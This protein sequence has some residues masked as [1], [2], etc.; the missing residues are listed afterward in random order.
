MIEQ[1][2]TN[3]QRRKLRP[4]VITLGSK[5]KAYIEALFNEPCM[6]DHFEP[7]AFSPGIPSRELRSCY[8]FFSHASKTGI[9]P[10]HEWDAIAKAK[11][12]IMN[13]DKVDD[14]NHLGLL[15]CLNDIP[16]LEGRR[17]SD[18]DV[19]KHY[20][21]ELWKKAK[22]INRGRNVLGCLFAHLIAMKKMVE[23]DYDFILEDNVRAP[24][25]SV[26]SIT[27][28]NGTCRGDDTGQFH[29][30]MALKQELPEKKT[31]MHASEIS[32]PPCA[33]RIRESI[34]ASQE[35]EL[36]TGKKCHL[37]Y[38]GWLGSRPNLEFI[39]NTHCPRTRYKRRGSHKS[40]A[41]SIFPFPVTSDF[42]NDSDENDEDKV[43]ARQPSK[44]G[45]ESDKK[46]PQKPGGTP[47]WGAYAYWISKEGHKALI[48]GL[49]KDVGSLLWKSKRMRHHLVKPIDKVMPRKILAHFSSS[50]KE[51]DGRDC[52]HVATDPAFFRAPMLTS[53]I[54]SQWDAEFCKSTE[55]QML[56]C[57]QRNSANANSDEIAMEEVWDSL[58]LTE[59][60]REIIAYKKL[61]QKWLTLDQLS[62]MSLQN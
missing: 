21:S 10:Q 18:E 62:E 40:E 3:G 49:Q 46:S 6:K 39:I 32:S 8:S 22:G 48:D 41:P 60:E 58:W 59:Q 35:W 43:Y 42:D 56:S 17:G 9:I 45:E 26:A 54:H 5:R 34:E 14:N 36:D 30:D 38:Y 24:I 15:D 31:T 12:D 61:E 53:Q 28:N 7:P 13:D 44:L 19:K 16:V 50:E 27:V 55:Y 52:I 57:W 47:I 11:E 1:R 23:E 25:S 37:R 33:T 2:D 51:E 4:L 29:G 20:C